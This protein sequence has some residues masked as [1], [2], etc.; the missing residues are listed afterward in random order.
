MFSRLLGKQFLA[1]ANAI[2][3]VAISVIQFTNLLEQLL[4]GTTPVY[5]QPREESWVDSFFC[6]RAIHR[7]RRRVRARGW[8]GMVFMEGVVGGG[9]GLWVFRSGIWWVVMYIVCRFG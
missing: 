5:Q 4:I 7:L 6:L 2:F 1:A 9:V 8:V 3:I